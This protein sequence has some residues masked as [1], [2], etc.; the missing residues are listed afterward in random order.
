[1]RPGRRHLRLGVL[2][3]VTVLVAGCASPPSQAPATGASPAGA[4][5]AAAASPAA[6]TGGLAGLPSDLD[7]TAVVAGY[8]GVPLQ[9]LDPQLAAIRDQLTKELGDAITGPVALPKAFGSVD[10]E[11]AVDQ[12]AQDIGS[13][14][15]LVTILGAVMP[16]QPAADAAASLVKQVGE[17]S[18]KDVPDGPKQ[19]STSH[20]IPLSAGSGAELVTGGYT[21]EVRAEQ[22]RSQ[23]TIDDNRSLTITGNKNGVPSTFDTEISSTVVVDF[24]PDAG[25][26]F[27]VHL[28]T[29]YKLDIDGSTTLA[30]IDG[31]FTGLVNDLGALATLTGNVTLQGGETQPDGSK[32]NS[33]SLSS[34]DLGFDTADGTVGKVNQGSFTGPAD[35]QALVDG[36]LA[37]AKIDLENSVPAIVAAAQKEWQGDS[38]V[39][40][41]VPDYGYMA[42]PGDSNSERK[43]VKAA[44]T[45]SFQVLVHHR[46]EH[47]DLTVPVQQ[48][49]RSEKSVDPPQI[50][51]TPGTAKYE[52][53]NKRDAY[54]TDE[55]RAWSRRGRS[56]LKIDFH[57]TDPPPKLKID[58]SFTEHAAVVTLT[59]KVTSPA[60][61][62]TGG[63][64]TFEATV[65][66][67]VTMKM[68]MQGGALPC[69]AVF[70]TERGTAH[71]TAHAQA[72][73]DTHMVWV[74]HADPA[75]MHFTSKAQC[76][77]SVG[78]F[79]DPSGGG[80]GAKFFAALHDFQVPTD[81]ATTTVQGTNAGAG[82]S[83]AASARVTVYA[84]Q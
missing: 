11:L 75:S 48:T 70:E 66:I 5:Q 59:G 28:T 62:F 54:N 33:Y 2:C 10:A 63:P 57:T 69:G 1:M 44:S 68:T 82:T 18:G 74:V 55:L 76:V 84:T 46:F 52:A 29:K 25:G 37:V 21:E 51:P 23:V 22:V 61:E 60:V 40:V 16:S 41:V 30:T 12:G 47:R 50:S 81:P 15:L 73:D 34:S 20:D 43:D 42:Q 31:S 64:D 17:T 26:G 14:V 80:F 56:D 72:I 71:L 39:I 8:L 35:T 9:P 24:C 4:T 65:P 79:L 45:S 77:I 53:P 36:K 49:L 58:G 27:P 7:P 13:A 67:S 38:C 6:S 78:N 32:S 83:D 3:T 19:D